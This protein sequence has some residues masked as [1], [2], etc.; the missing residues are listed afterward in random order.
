MNQFCAI[1][2]YRD[3]N[4]AAGGPTNAP[5]RRKRRGEKTC[6]ISAKTG[7]DAMPVEDKRCVLR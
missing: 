5:R 1:L 7:F 4:A 6:F 2:D 3:L